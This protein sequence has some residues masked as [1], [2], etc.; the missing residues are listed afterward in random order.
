MKDVADL[1]EE[2]EEEEK[3]GDFSYFIPEIGWNLCLLQTTAA[4]RGLIG[5][6]VGF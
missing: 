5:L 2:E 1:V 3:K 6:Y 4:T